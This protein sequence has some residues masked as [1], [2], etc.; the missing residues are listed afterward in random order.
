MDI[1]VFRAAFTE[2]TDTAKYPDALVS[3][4]ATLAT[5]QVNAD[6]WGTQTTLGIQLYVAHEITLE[7]QSQASA[8]IGGVPGAQSGPTNTKTVGSVTIGYDTDQT[9]EKDAGFWNL[10]VYG[11]Q[12]I[13]LARIFGAGVIQL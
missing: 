7:A 6:R 13:R 11:K 2:F 3:F 9:K 8:A 1:S 10:T 5:A 4:W 12:F